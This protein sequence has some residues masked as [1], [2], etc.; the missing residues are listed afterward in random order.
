MPAGQNVLAD[1]QAMHLCQLHVMM[2]SFNSKEDKVQERLQQQYVK[3]AQ[4]AVRY[5]LI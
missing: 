4:L 3:A 2:Q 5:R 1:M